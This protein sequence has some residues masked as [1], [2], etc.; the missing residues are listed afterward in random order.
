MLVKYTALEYKNDFCCFKVS[1]Y[2][3]ILLLSSRMQAIYHKWSARKQRLHLQSV[4]GISRHSALSEDSSRQYV[5][6][7]GSRRKDTD[8]SVSESRHFLLQAPQCPCSVRK[9]FSRN[10]CC[11]GRSKPGC[12]F[13]GSHTKWELSTWADFQLCLHRLLMSTGSA[14]AASWMSVVAM[15][16]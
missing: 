14:T 5:T 12:W 8:H 1:L 2:Y 7:S 3:N 9:R 16:G 15:V 4:A 13:V 11:R 10:Y 6:S